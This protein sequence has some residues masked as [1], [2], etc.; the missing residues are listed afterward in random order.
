MR[1]EHKLRTHL[2]QKEMNRLCSVN[3]NFP[4]DNNLLVLDIV[5]S[6]LWA[7]PQ[8]INWDNVAKLVPGFT[9]KECARRFEELKSTG[10]FPHLDEQC[11]PLTGAVSSPS[12][13]FPNYIK[14]NLLDVNTDAGEPQTNKVPLSMSGASADSECADPSKTIERIEESKSPNMVIHV[15]DEAKNLKQDFVCPR[16]LLVKEMRYFEEY[17]SVDPQRW[18]EVDISVHCDVQIFDWLMNYVKSHNHDELHGKQV[19]KPKLE[20]SNVISILISSEF[21]KMDTLVEEC[22]QY[23]H[24]NMSGII[25]TPCNM[26]CI[27]NTLA[28][29]IA[30]LFNHNEADE[31]KDKKDK[32]KRCGL[33]LKHLTKE[34]ERIIPCVPSKINI[35]AHGNIVFSHS[36]D[37][38][39][40]VHEYVTG[41]YDELKSWDLVYWRIWGTINHLT[42]S[43]C[44]Q[45][46]LCTEL[47]Q[48]KY[49][50]E[51]IVYP[52]VNADHRW[53][54]VGV[55]PC[56]NQDV[57]RFD[58]SSIPKGC[59]I[60]DHILTAEDGGDCGAYS[61]KSTHTRI[62]RDLL[63]HREAVCAPERLACAN[64]NH[65]L[66]SIK[67]LELSAATKK[68]RKSGK[69]LKRQASS[70]N[71][72]RKDKSGEKATSRD[73]TPFTVSIQKNKWDS[74]RSLRYN[75]DAQREEVL[76][77]KAAGGL[78]S[79]LEAQFKASS[80]TS[81]RQSSSEKTLRC[82]SL[83]TSRHVSAPCNICN[84]RVTPM[85]HLQNVL[86]PY[87]IISKCRPR[88]ISTKR[89][90]SLQDH[91]QVVTPGDICHTYQP[92]LTSATLV[93]VSCDICDM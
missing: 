33:C 15:C 8:P 37:K 43:R 72:Q 52:G 16:N 46:F 50:P 92:C 31:L 41:L 59:K 5:L 40:E 58:P 67:E 22:V 79:R 6:S 78:Y 61:V 81:A 90:A 74:N 14:S 49:H 85:R 80:Q 88:A 69:P 82:R 27:N 18:D 44:K 84:T 62:L 64:H 42:C 56:C 75:Q 30:N 38:V 11:N 28:R 77:L 39:W 70:P 73:S 32:F 19:E 7:S 76:L 54:G 66:F 91:R 48:C 20:H 51:A 68:A 35:D 47:R 34:T 45:A 71:F 4:Y 25:A 1:E 65:S 21:L 23:C 26:N 36:R 93:S 24:K 3:N 17:L 86:V 87:D 2:E 57:L 53:R 9:P 29:R 13:S 55:Y 83:M 60:K 10:S 12:E 89:V 63:L